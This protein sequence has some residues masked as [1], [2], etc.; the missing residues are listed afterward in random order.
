MLAATNEP[1]ENWEPILRPYL[2]QPTNNISEER[3]E[4]TMYYKLYKKSQPANNNNN[5]TNIRKNTKP[6]NK[7]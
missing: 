4:T 3:K 6:R 1:T 5:S 2:E 7:K